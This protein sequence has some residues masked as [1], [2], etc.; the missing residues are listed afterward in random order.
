MCLNYF[1]YFLILYLHL[2]QHIHYCLQIKVQ[3]DILHLNIIREV[4]D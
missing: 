4:K 2:M 1:F 3:N